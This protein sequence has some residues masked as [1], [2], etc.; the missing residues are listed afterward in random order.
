MR[1]IYLLLPLALL[2]SA[3]QQQGNGADKSSA[4]I[5]SVDIEDSSEAEY[6]EFTLVNWEEEK[7]RENAG[8]FSLAN[9]FMSYVSD[10]PG[11]KKESEWFGILQPKMVSAFDSVCPSAK[12]LD[13][14]GK[15]DSMV[16]I[17][18]SFILGGS[19]AETTMDM[20]HKSSLCYCFQRYKLA[21]CNSRLMKKNPKFSSEI[22]SW[23]KLDTSI[24]G[25]MTNVACFENYGGSIVG[26]NA[27]HYDN[28]L[29]SARLK[30]L[31]NL[32]ADNK[33][34]VAESL[35]E[36][37]RNFVQA[38][39]DRYT[40]IA[41]YDGMGEGQKEILDKLTVL[42]GN[43]LNSLDSWLNARNNSGIDVRG[44]V[45]LLNDLE[46]LLKL[47]LSENCF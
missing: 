19:D 27:L 22:E 4:V 12:N 26:L 11:L 15:A 44:T 33:I 30:S 10:E 37:K 16:C 1:R 2:C 42:K 40:K 6:G 7:N 39:N 35:D 34:V 36:A 29:F 31:N 32:I 8:Y 41:N 17:L 46:K 13:E 38:L 25:F 3:C 21:S 24:S 28:E 47:N 14:S 23:I 9:S 18:E 43:V 45:G 5:D 20:L